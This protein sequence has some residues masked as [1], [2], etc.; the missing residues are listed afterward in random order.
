M[1]KRKTRLTLIFSVFGVVLLAVLAGFIVFYFASPAIKTIP[2]NLRI[3][4]DEGEFYIVCD[5]Q[6]DFDYY[7][8]IEQSVDEE[9]VLVKE[10]R[11]D[12]NRL[13]LQE[14]GLLL[15]A[16]NI[17]RFRVAFIGENEGTGSYSNN[18]VWKVT[19]SFQGIS[20][21]L[22]GTILSWD[23]VDLCDHYLIK[24]TNPDTTTSEIELPSTQTSFDFS[25][26]ESGV[27]Q[28]YVVAVA[29]NFYSAS[30]EQFT[31]QIM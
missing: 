8:V 18:F 6:T 5:Y 9:F 30:S 4:Q 24:I 12:V 21:Q 16:G 2:Q 17:F 29:D 27:Y 19:A 22:N 10:V 28:V 31:F 7:F 1:V 25:S 20:A 3:E 26:Y 14:N 11:S 23:E 13:N 15:H